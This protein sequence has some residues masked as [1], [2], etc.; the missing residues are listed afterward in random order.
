MRVAWALGIVL[1]ALVVV[2]GLANLAGGGSFDDE[3]DR[4][5]YGAVQV[6]AG[7]SIATGLVISARSRGASIGLVG[8]GVIA[9]SAVMPWFILF[10]VP[11][12]LGLVALVN[13]RRRLRGEGS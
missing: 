7:A 9:I 12:G 4:M 8:A 1:V 3:T 2:H 5:V 6:L 13:S 10:T 11:V